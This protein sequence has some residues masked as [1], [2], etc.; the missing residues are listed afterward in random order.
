MKDSKIDHNIAISHQIEKKKP[1]FSVII[2]TKNEEAHIVRCLDS[3][4]EAQF[5]SDGYEIIVVD[6]GSNDRTVSLSK[7]MNVV[8]F[9]MPGLTV[10]GLRNYG[11]KHSHGKILAFIDA[12]CE[13]GPNW[14]NDAM[15]YENEIKVVCFGAPPRIPKNST[16]VQKSWYQIRGKQTGCFETAWLESMN[17][18]IRKEI[19]LKVGGFNENLTTCEDYDI[20]LRLAKE[21][22][23]ISDSRILAV[24]HGEAKDLRHFFIKEMWRGISNWQGVILHGLT[25][26]ELP[27]LCVPPIY[28]CFVLLLLFGVIFSVDLCF[29]I[30]CMFVLVFPSIL[31]ALRRVDDK[32]DIVSVVQ[33]ALLLNIYFVARGISLIRR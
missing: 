32:K 6:N 31:F 12:D 24:H 10:A 14:F 25:L 15:T 21:G 20:S 8:V 9:E 28:S 18:F 30:T 19:F 11:A 29:V 16:W 13:V 27:S 3:I 1:I 2:P 22:K 17:M 33:L 7:R 23:I 26:R 5:D 4:K